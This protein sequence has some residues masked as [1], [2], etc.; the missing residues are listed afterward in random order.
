MSMMKYPREPVHWLL[1]YKNGDAFALALL[2]E[3]RAQTSI[4]SGKVGWS[5]QPPSE[6]NFMIEDTRSEKE[7]TV[8]NYDYEKIPLP[9]WE[10]LREFGLPVLKVS[11]DDD[12]N[13][14]LEI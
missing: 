9:Q 4:H 11:D 5:I 12:E 3:V 14:Y 8:L 6:F 7:C 2:P 1:R 10:T 13:R